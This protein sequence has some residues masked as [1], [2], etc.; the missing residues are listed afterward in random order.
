MVWEPA[1]AVVFVGQRSCTGPAADTACGALNFFTSRATA[2][3]WSTQ[4]HEFTGNAVDQTRAEALGQAVFG[5]LLTES[6]HA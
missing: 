2:H 6:D 4:H 1:T 5:R 3:K